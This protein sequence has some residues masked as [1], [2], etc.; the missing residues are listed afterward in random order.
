MGIPQFY[1]YIL[2]LWEWVRL[3]HYH[4]IEFTEIRDPSNSAVLIGYDKTGEATGKSS[5]PIGISTPSAISLAN[6]LLNISF[7]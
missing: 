2:D 1:H 4:F 7:L 6:S 5:V 3:E